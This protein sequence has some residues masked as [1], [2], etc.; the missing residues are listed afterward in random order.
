MTLYVYTLLICLLL[1]NEIIGQENNPYNF[2]GQELISQ[3]KLLIEDFN[4]HKIPI[5]TLEIINT[6]LETSSIKGY[7]PSALY[8]QLLK[9]QKTHYTLMESKFQIDQNSY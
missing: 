4:T 2:K 1:P 9:S 7:L 3:N 6:N 5:D 8:Q